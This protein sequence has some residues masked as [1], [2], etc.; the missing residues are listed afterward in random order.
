MYAAERGPKVKISMTSPAKPP[1]VPAWKPPSADLG[2]YLDCNKKDFKMATFSATDDIGACSTAAPSPAL[3]AVS[4]GST[5]S[6]S[7]H[8]GNTPGGWGISPLNGAIYDRRG[9]RFPS[10]MSSCATDGI[11]SPQS[12]QFLLPEAEKLS[13]QEFTLSGVKDF[14]STMATLL[15]NMAPKEQMPPQPMFLSLPPG[16]T[17]PPLPPPPLGLLNMDLGLPK[18]KDPWTV[19]PLQHGFQMPPCTVEDLH[20]QFQVNHVDVQFQ[21]PEAKTY[22]ACDLPPGTTTIMLRNIPNKYTQERLVEVIFDAG[23]VGDINFLYLPVDFKNKCNVG[24]AF[25]NF[26]TEEACSRFAAEFHLANSWEKLPGFNSQKVC[27]VSSA[28]FQG[29]SENVSRL[30]SSP[31][32]AQL[33]KQPQWLPQLFDQEGRPCDFPLPATPM[34]PPVRQRGRLTRRGV[35]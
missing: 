10:D 34:A 23:Y 7:F 28:K 5:P 19:R 9:S 21:A 2:G 22:T 30:R 11:N 13:S 27:E 3:T 14:E 26:R 24:Y 18:K 12:E 4:M 35:A 15:S 33:A 6:L 31:V 17:T 20:N 1:P 8:G 32:M 16:L 29:L 25:L